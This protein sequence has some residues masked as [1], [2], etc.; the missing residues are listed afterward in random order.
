MDD[1]EKQAEDTE[2]EGSDSGGTINDPLTRDVE[3]PRKEFQGR[4]PKDG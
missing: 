2:S 3:A 1:K 4:K